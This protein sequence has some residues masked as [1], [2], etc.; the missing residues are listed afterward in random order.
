[1]AGTGFAVGARGSQDPF[2]ESARAP[3]PGI[4]DIGSKK[5][6]FLD[7][8]LIAHSSRVS[9]FMGRPRKYPQNPVLTA[10][11]PWEKHNPRAGKLPADGVQ[12][13]GQAVLYDQEEKIFKM[14]Y[15][16]WSFFPSRLRP[17]CYA[18][19]K[20]G[21]RWEKPELGIYSYQGSQNNNILAAYTRSKYFNVFKDNKET[22]PQKR[23]KAMGEVEGSERNGTAVAF[24]PDGLNWTEF[25]DNPVVLKGRDIADCPT[26][27]GWDP[28]IQKYVYYPRPGPPLGTRVNG[29]GFHLPPQGLN[30]NEG[31]IGCHT[32]RKCAA[33][34]F[35]EGDKIGIDADRNPGALAGLVVPICSGTEYG[36]SS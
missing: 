33:G 31:Q 18:I 13:S 3:V 35:N 17:W 6:L 26:F 36:N 10:D 25:A 27:L 12:I 15:N 28:R 23:Y 4:L 5:Q 9:R 8:T 1:M 21:Y 24:S 7:D 2:V 16:P 11:K 19:S 34:L 20:D 22:D 30:L 29:K 14:W 32:N